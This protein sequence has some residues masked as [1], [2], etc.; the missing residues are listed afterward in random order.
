MISDI[1]TTDIKASYTVSRVLWTL[2]NTVFE[3]D[4]DIIEAFHREGNEL[5]YLWGF[6][7]IKE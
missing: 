5:V 3:N 1:E 2:L 7:R 6:S 4:E